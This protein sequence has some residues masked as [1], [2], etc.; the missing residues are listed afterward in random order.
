MMAGNRL[1]VRDA[2]RR[3][4]GGEVRERGVARADE[5]FA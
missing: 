2:P 5:P 4:V 3:V 1:L